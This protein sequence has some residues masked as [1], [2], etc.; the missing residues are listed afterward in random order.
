[1]L[2]VWGRRHGRDAMRAVIDVLKQTWKE[3]GEDHA[4]RLAAALA[5]YVVFSIAPLLVVLTA[6]AGAVFD[7]ATVRREVYAQL[8]GLLGGEGARA[9]YE[10]MERA[11]VSKGGVLATVLGGAAI[12][13]G[14]GGVFEQLR[15]A[16]DTIW[17]VRRKKLP[18]F[19][20]F[21]KEHVFSLALV[22]GSGFLLLVSLLVNAAVAALVHSMHD[23][24]PGSDA[25]WQAGYYV[26]STLAAWGVFAAAFKVLPDV[27]IPWREVAHGA[28]WT[29]VL[30]S[31]GQVLLGL[32]LGRGAFGNA[33]G[34]AGSFV[35]LLVWTYYSSQVLL[36]GAELTQVLARR[37]DVRVEPNPGSEPA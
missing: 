16:L 11:N 21:L 33:Y 34:A 35:V 12:L 6:I 18:F 26:V 2:T 10:I 30:F 7:A 15:D 29:A 8:Q 17:E 3:F 5:Y 27:R 13:L 23:R 19:R 22:V 31:L 1:M 4:P 20:G 14:A 24:L 37:R 32:Y 25:L 28:F 36:F 9:A